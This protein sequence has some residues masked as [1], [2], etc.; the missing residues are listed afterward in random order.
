MENLHQIPCFRDSISYIY[1]E[2]GRLDRDSKSIAFHDKEG[3]TRIPASSSAVIL[4]GPGTKVTHAAISTAAD[5]N[6][7]LIWVGEEGVRFYAYGSG[8]TRN[9]DLLLHQASL[10]S[11][12]NLRLG[13]VRRMYAMRFGEEPDPE[14]SVERLR[15]LEGAR[16]RKLYEEMS[17]KTGIRWRGRSYDRGNWSCADPVN[18]ALSAAN[19]CLYGICHAAILSVGL[20]PGLGFIHTGKQLSFVYDIADLYKADLTI[21]MAFDLAVA[22]VPQIETR[23]RWLCRDVFRKTRIMK[24]I[25]PDIFN[26]LGIMTDISDSPYDWDPARPGPLWDPSYLEGDD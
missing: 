22:G 21:P 1:L 24:R 5:N 26:I 6:C 15:G 9:S 3:I 4:L 13:V 19:S 12:S 7:L 23:A 14:F 2:R 10:C 25:I 18:R 8:G 16:V 17:N 20:S 11:D